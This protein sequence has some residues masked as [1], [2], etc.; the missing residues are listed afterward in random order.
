MI[1][2]S[3][4][5]YKP[6]KEVELFI[7]YVFN[8]RGSQTRRQRECSEKLHTTFER[9]STAIWRMIRERK[10]VKESM[11]LENNNYSATHPTDDIESLAE[12]LAT[13][14]T[15]TAAT[16]KTVSTAGVT[17]VTADKE[18]LELALACFI[19]SLEERK[20]IRRV[21]FKKEWNV[22]TFKI[23]AANVFLKELEMYQKEQERKIRMNIESFENRSG[24]YL[25]VSS[26]GRRTTRPL[27]RPGKGTESYMSIHSLSPRDV[28]VSDATDKSGIYS[29]GIHSTPTN[30]G[31]GGS[32]VSRAE[33]P[34]GDF[35]ISLE[36]SLKM[37]PPQV[38]F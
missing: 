17:P 28:I 14:T 13:V 10:K 22:E 11:N 26:R 3:E 5:P 29:S 38:D 20:G 24:G 8:K 9:I 1:E 15:V 32:G 6:L 19:V 16:A 2:N 7:G 12:S 36:S 30:R 33:G 4:H 23:L 21:T 25:G 35:K 37:I 31:I 18:V 27:Q 34:V